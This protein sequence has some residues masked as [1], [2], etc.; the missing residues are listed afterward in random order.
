MWWCRVGRTLLCFSRGIV[1]SLACLV[2]LACLLLTPVCFISTRQWSGVPAPA[3]ESSSNVAASPPLPCTLDN[4]TNACLLVPGTAVWLRRLGPLLFEERLAGPENGFLLS[5]WRDAQFSKL[6]EELR[7]DLGDVVHRSHLMSFFFDGEWESCT[8]S[9]RR[10]A[11]RAARAR[12]AMQEGWEWAGLVGRWLEMLDESEWGGVGQYLADVAA[13]ALELPLEYKSAY[14]VHSDILDD[15]RQSLL[16]C[17]RKSRVRFQIGASKASHTVHDL[18][19]SLRQELARRDAL[20][21]APPPPPPPPPPLSPLRRWLLPC[22][23]PDH[24][25]T[26][27]TDALP[28]SI[29]AEISSAIDEE[30]I[31]QLHHL[32]AWLLMLDLHLKLRLVR[33]EALAATIEM[34][35]G[36]LD[37]FIA[38]SSKRHMP[39][40][41]HSAGLAAL[42]R[43]LRS[44]SRLPDRVAAG[45]ARQWEDFQRKHHSPPATE[46]DSTFWQL[47]AAGDE[48]SFGRKKEYRWNLTPRSIGR[49][50][51]CVIGDS[52]VP[53]P[54][55]GPGFRE[56]Y[57][58]DEEGD[59]KIFYCIDA[60]LTGLGDTRDLLELDGAIQIALEL[61]AEVVQSERARRAE[62]QGLEHPSWT[63]QDGLV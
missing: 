33:D 2:A 1:C 8:N 53:M 59:V 49:S 16:A 14:A 51:K 6:A 3:P 5:E 58:V 27:H 52:M 22:F 43:L 13:D 41:E 26:S 4:A 63:Q 19:N 40:P 46:S 17:K 9:L 55:Y 39:Q 21:R 37:Q 42:L 18:H 34:A 25:S 47:W 45:Y 24:D 38:P 62:Q 12:A 44:V 29:D 11:E 57:P 61:Q 54:E 48:D 7:W 23:R 50:R 28:S 15:A 56:P 60:V 20:T 32:A 35:S 30:S 10:V 31:R 36:E